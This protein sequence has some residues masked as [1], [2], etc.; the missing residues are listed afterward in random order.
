[1]VLS[2]LLA[3]ASRRSRAR[4][5][6]VLIRAIPAGSVVLAVGVDPDG[7]DPRNA[8]LI[9]TALA[10][11]R[12]V[13]GLLYEGVPPAVFVKQSRGLVF[14]DGRQLP[15]ATGAFDFVI[16]NAVVEHVGG[17]S[18]MQRFIAESLRVARVGVIHTT[19]NRWFP[20]ETHTGLPLF[21]WLPRSLH[22][23]LLR[24]SRYRFSASDR[25]LSK[26]E[27]RSLFPT[28]VVIKGYPGA[29]P[30]TLVATATVGPDE[31]ICSHE[32]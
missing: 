29:I 13:T 22:V 9:E 4:K 20:I 17:I 24:N 30:M 1:M 21:H 3:V 2:D 23:R 5:A 15:F 10:R 18:D 6:S 7:G 8:N 28:G 16:S 11:A 19:P 12:P 27:L 14:G 25:L 32:T 26:R 31:A